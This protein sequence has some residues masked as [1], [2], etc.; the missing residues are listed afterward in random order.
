[1]IC[2]GKGSVH[3]ILTPEELRDL[4]EDQYD[5]NILFLSADIS[6]RG[7]KSINISLNIRDMEQVK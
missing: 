7:L 4:L 1:M 2:C 5:Y 6:P 3:K